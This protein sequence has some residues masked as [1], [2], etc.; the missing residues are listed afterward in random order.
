MIN[1]L[2]NDI[3]QSRKAVEIDSDPF[4]IESCLWKPISCTFLQ[5]STT[6]IDTARTYLQLPLRQCLPHSVVQLKGKHCRK[7]HCRYWVVDTF[8][9]NTIVSNEHVD[10]WLN[11]HNFVSPNLKLHNHYYH[12]LGAK[13]WKFFPYQFT[14][15]KQTIHFDEH[16]LL[17]RLAGSR[18]IEL[19]YRSHNA[20]VVPILRFSISK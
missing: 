14:S 15:I 6:F 5:L 11:L 19:T 2:Q 7:P 12:I 10:F 9:H 8:G 3:V 18:M 17:R 16:P 13:G 1:V 4:E 20:V